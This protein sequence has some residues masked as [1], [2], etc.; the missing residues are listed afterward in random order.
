MEE[1]NYAFVVAVVVVVVG[2]LVVAS[3]AACLA[4]HAAFSSSVNVTY[5][6]TFES[7]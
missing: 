3:R 4:S 6:G 2:D 5:T 1:E 7:G